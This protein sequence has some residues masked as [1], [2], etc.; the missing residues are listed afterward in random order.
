MSVAALT[1]RMVQLQVALVA[2]RVLV[3]VRMV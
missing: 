1:V 2:Q 3:L